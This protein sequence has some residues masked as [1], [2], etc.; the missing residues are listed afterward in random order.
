MNPCDSR[1]P[2]PRG[3]S[4]STQPKPPIAQRTATL[5][6]Q[7]RERARGEPGDPGVEPVARQAERLS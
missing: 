7:G 4:F 6:A 5:I 3:V 1:V 2:V